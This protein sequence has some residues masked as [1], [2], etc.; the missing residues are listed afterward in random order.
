MRHA[1][2]GCMLTFCLTVLPAGPAFTQNPSSE[3]S[4]AAT[5]SASDVA[6]VYVGTHKG[7]YLYNAAANGK[8]TLVS[9]S[10]FK[11]TGLIIGSNGAYLI[12]LGTYY[13]HSY[14]VAS[15]GA[16]KKQVSAID[17]RNYYGN[18]YCEGGDNSGGTI[19]L[20]SLNHSGH[21]LYVVFPL[22][23]GVCAASIQTYNI[24]KSGDLT[25][26]DGIMTGGDAG[27]GLYQAPTITAND[28]FAYA[29]GDFY[30]CGQP[31]GF[32][33]YKL[34]SKGEM[35]NW[36]FN[37]S[38]NVSPD[39]YSPLYVTADPTNHLAAIMAL[40][41]EESFGPGQL[42]SYTV[43][44]Q[45]NLSTTATAENMPYPEVDPSILNI[46]PSGKFVA[47]AGSSGVQVF[48]FNGPSPITHYS[49]VLTTA[50]IDAIQWDNSNHLYALS[51]STGKLYV[52]TITPTS[53]T[54]AYGSPY[55]ITGTN[56]LVVVAI[57]CSAPSSA[58]VHI[59]SPASGSSVSSPVQVE[60]SAKI[61]GT[62][63]STQLWAD[64]VKVDS[65]ASNSL[66]ASI[67]L[68]AGAHRFAVVTSNT[69]GKK[70][71]SA[72]NATVK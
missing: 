68:S 63:A 58:G 56:A 6:H 53:I 52:Y 27:S 28:T 2:A 15:N 29:A 65:T 16:V 48:H 18:G 70:W 26:N 51:N 39:Q 46:S 34:G 17:T 12:S 9:G 45:G 1:A 67:S 24:T 72:V 55:K 3:A 66:D 42:A 25:F 11:T 21:N 36:T 47:V 14:P 19:G 22:D 5:V 38:F 40:D 44:G 49:G 4:P 31:G 71:E 23:T 61:T 35:Q 50:P 30:C 43:D 59:C 57:P 60:A 64:G 33:G 41:E 62:I 32:S 54:E 13:V 10:P 7:V 20:A 69:A 8:L 37:M